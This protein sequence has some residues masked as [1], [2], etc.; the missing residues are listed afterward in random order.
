MCWEKWDVHY[1]AGG[2]C[3]ESGGCF[4][5]ALCH[6]MGWGSPLDRH[7]MRLLKFWMDLSGCAAHMAPEYLPKASLTLAGFCLL[8]GLANGSCSSQAL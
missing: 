1:P 3:G 7:R 5:A 6:L 2:G 4:Q 8:R